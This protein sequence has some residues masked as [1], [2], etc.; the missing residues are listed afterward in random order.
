[1]VPGPHSEDRQPFMLSQHSGLQVLGSSHC[2]RCRSSGQLAVH[3]H[4][5]RLAE[6]LAGTRS[7]LHRYF[8]ELPLFPEFHHE[9]DPTV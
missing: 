1:M 7:W 5:D 4:D 3:A 9:L 8:S 2:K 6:Q